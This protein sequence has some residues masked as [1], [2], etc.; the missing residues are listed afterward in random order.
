MK[1]IMTAAIL[2]GVMALTAAPAGAGTSAP[3]GGRI[4]RKVRIAAFAFYPNDPRVVVGEVVQVRNLDWDA[5]GEPHTLTSIN[6]I[7]STGVVKGDIETFT[8]PAQTGR[9]E[10]KCVIHPFMRGLLIVRRP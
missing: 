3:Q 5:F 2:A 7:F 10:F 8:A 6:G 9:Y 4:D 1:R